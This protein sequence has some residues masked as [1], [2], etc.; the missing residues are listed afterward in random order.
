MKEL[1][2]TLPESWERWGRSPFLQSSHSFHFPHDQ[3]LPHTF[4]PPLLFPRPLRWYPQ[5]SD[6][7][8]TYRLLCAL[9]TPNLEWIT[10][11]T[12]VGDARFTLSLKA[13]SNRDWKTLIKMEFPPLLYT[14]CSAAL[15]HHCRVVHKCMRFRTYPDTA[16]LSTS[17]FH[18][19]TRISPR[20][21]NLNVDLTAP[22]R[23]VYSRYQ[24]PLPWNWSPDFVLHFSVFIHP[25]IS[26][27]KP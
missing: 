7:F 10:S 9:D 8:R 14:V 26:L 3:L 5:H 2:L 17:H 11:H 4:S 15:I 19:E 21:Q 6:S 18:K 16:N 1:Q 23:A 20:R 22:S 12:L 24:R 25:C 27:C 13:A